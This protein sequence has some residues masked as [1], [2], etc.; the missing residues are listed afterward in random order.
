MKS[1][2]MLRFRIVSLTD[3]LRFVCEDCCTVFRCPSMCDVVAVTGVRIAETIDGCESGTE[4]MFSK[5]WPLSSEM[6][7]G[8]L[9]SCHSDS[10][11]TFLF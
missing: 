1:S 4:R 5:A 10:P 2:W 7:S 9:E 11:S 8:G 6:S 3:G